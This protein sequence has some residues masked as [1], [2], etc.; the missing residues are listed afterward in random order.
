MNQDEAI[1]ALN[2][3][4]EEASN[5]IVAPIKTPDQSSLLSTAAAHFRSGGNWFG[6]AMNFGT[7]IENVQPGYNALHDGVLGTN[8]EAHADTFIGSGNAD[9]TARRKQII[10]AKIQDAETINNASNFDS[11]IGM[12]VSAAV[13]PINIVPVFNVAAKAKGLT[14]ALNAASGAGQFAAASVVGQNLLNISE[15]ERKLEALPIAVSAVLGGAIGGAIGKV[16]QANLDSMIYQKSIINHILRTGEPPIDHATLSAVDRQTAILNKLGELESTNKVSGDSLAPG[17]IVFSDIGNEY[18]TVVGKNTQA[19]SGKNPTSKNLI[20][21]KLNDGTII[22][23]TSDEISLTSPVELREKAESEIPLEVEALA[24]DNVKGAQTLEEQ[25]QQESISAMRTE[26][27]DI[28]VQGLND[29]VIK[30]VQIPGLNN[31]SLRGLVS[32][33]KTVRESVARLY[34]TPLRLKGQ[35]GNAIVSMED[36]LHMDRE[37]IIGVQNEHKQNYYSYLGTSPG[38]T[39]GLRAIKDSKQ[40]GKLNLEQFNEETSK[41]LRNK[42]EH[43]IPQVAASAKVIRKQIDRLTKRMQELGILDENLIVKFADSYFMRVYDIE[44][45]QKNRYSFEDIHT[46]WFIQHDKSLNGDVGLARDKAREIADNILGVGDKEIG[47]SEL[48]RLSSEKGVRFT[49]ERENPIDDN[50]LAEFLVNDAGQV[51][52]MFMQQANQMIRFQEFLDDM[53]V[54]SI[55]GLRTRLQNEYQQ[56]LSILNNRIAMAKGDEIAKFNKDAEQLTKDFKAGIDDLNAF[57]ATM[58]GQYAHKTKADKYLRMW[59]T[60]NYTRLMGY[61]VMSSLT[62]PAVLVLRNGLGRTLLNGWGGALTEFAN[63]MKS[64][65]RQDLQDIVNG[66][67]GGMDG[68][69]RRILDGGMDSPTIKGRAEQSM[70]MMGDIFTELTGINH[71]NKFHKFM[72]A[73]VIESRVLDAISDVNRSAEQADDLLQLGIDKSMIDRIS[74]MQKQYGFTKNG[75][76]ISNI[77]QWSDAEAAFAYK[78]AINKEIRSTVLQPGKGDIPLIVQK[79][80]AASVMF[81]MKGFFASSTSRIL[82]SGMQRRDMNVL[83]SVMGLVGLGMFQ[84][85]VRQHISGREPNMDMNNLLIEGINRSGMLGLLQDPVFAFVINPARGT[86][87]SRYTNQNPSEYIFGP[88]ASALKQALT[89]STGAVNAATSGQF[90]L[91][92]QSEKA[93]LGLIPFNNLFYLDKFLKNR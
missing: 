66:L 17:N 78:S 15:P 36:R 81:Q 86:S 73:R 45:I 40:A 49:K 6:S 5:N 59:K 14:T 85:I 23:H 70:E 89:F 80:Q 16:M 2:F 74:T 82:L 26:Q 24:P 34:D 30:A 12:I 83:S 90:D 38:A 46:K 92:K 35:Q 41:A 69:I 1:D 25:I 54:D 76:H 4:G 52:N 79:Y 27:L 47:L 32:R 33:F 21:I 22:Q 75:T 29:A 50:T 53:G 13:D 71:W 61:M 62:D 11:A 65:K 7:E 67:E 42:D 31:P 19:A 93:G 51:T 44:K 28:R 55:Q 60:Y 58:L 88:S 72:A 9:E 18:G 43:V 20:N 91:D 84:Y 63:G 48:S 56:T 10:D 68:T 39:Q 8:Y 57:V 77:K 87:L 64:L 3:S 37:D